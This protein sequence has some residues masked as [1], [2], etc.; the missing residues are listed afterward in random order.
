MCLLVSPCVALERIQFIMSTFC[1]INFYKPLVFNYAIEFQEEV[2]K[3][4]TTVL[5]VKA[6]QKI[7]A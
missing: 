1:L 5:M 6:T 2:S 4:K 7:P 3:N